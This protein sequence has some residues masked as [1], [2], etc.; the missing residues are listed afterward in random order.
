VLILYENGQSQWLSKL[1]VT[2]TE[3]THGFGTPSGRIG[4]HAY[5]NTP[6]CKP[7]DVRIAP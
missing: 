6:A 7:N 3:T 5:G 4:R 1:L 2:L